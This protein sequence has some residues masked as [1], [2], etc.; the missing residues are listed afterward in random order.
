MANKLFDTHD[1]AKE[2]IDKCD[3][4]NVAMIDEEGLPYVLPFNFGYEDEKIYL[5]AGPAGRKVDIL[6]NNPNVC[7]S[8]STDHQL[9]QRHDTVACSSGMRYRSVL[10]RGKA[11]FID[12]FDEKVRIM[13][14]IMR[15]YIGKDFSYSKPSIKSL[16]VWSIEVDKIETKISG[17]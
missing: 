4:C 13:N 2:V 5:H 3:S 11:K 16:A 9:Y 8:F 14:V 6:D 1:K 7:V 17:Y 15:K 10:A 12:D